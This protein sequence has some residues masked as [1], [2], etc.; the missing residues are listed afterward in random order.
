MHFATAAKASRRVDPGKCHSERPAYLLTKGG[1][2]TGR[3]REATRQ[4]QSCLRRPVRDRYRRDGLHFVGQVRWRRFLLDRAVRH[5]DS[6]VAAVFDVDDTARPPVLWFEGEP[7]DRAQRTES[8]E[9]DDE[10][11]S[12]KEQPVQQLA[13][14]SPPVIG[15]EVDGFDAGIASPP[16]RDTS[17]TYGGADTRRVASDPVVGQ[18]LVPR[19]TK[20]RGTT[21]SLVKSRKRRNQAAGFPASDRALNELSVSGRVDKLKKGIGYVWRLARRRLRCRLIRA[22]LVCIVRHAC[23]PSNS[24]P[25]CASHRCPPPVGSASPDARSCT[26]TLPPRR[27][28][29]T[30]VRTVSSLHPYRLHFDRCCGRTHLRE[31]T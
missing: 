17:L 9:A 24:K 10:E 3:R 19:A 21:L 28:L 22:R 27:P 16:G 26:C 31:T 30:A 14:R 5:H 25:N 13:H 20:S 2:E 1:Y 15:P 6:R 12:K 23:L 11:D 7:K 18:F 8:G 4:I 29:D